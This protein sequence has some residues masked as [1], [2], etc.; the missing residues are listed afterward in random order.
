MVNLDS[1]S[2][3]MP[4]E[5]EMEEMEFSDEEDAWEP[6]LPLSEK[7]PLKEKEQEQTEPE[8]EKEK[9]AETDIDPQQLPILTTPAHEACPADTEKNQAEPEPQA[10]EAEVQQEEPQEEQEEQEEENLDHS[11]PQ[12]E[13]EEHPSPNNSE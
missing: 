11:L 3:E 4:V 12:A 6:L 9:E 13:W 2:E 1:D 7:P 10:K 5:E 8:K